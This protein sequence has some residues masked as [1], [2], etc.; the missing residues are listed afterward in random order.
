[1]R[2]L[3]SHG[4]EPLDDV[5]TVGDL[6]KLEEKLDG[7][8]LPPEPVGRPARGP[9]LGACRRD[10]RRIGALDPVDF[11]VFELDSPFDVAPVGGGNP[12]QAMLQTPAVSGGQLWR[13]E[14]LSVLVTFDPA[15]PEDPVYVTV[16]DQLPQVSI[17]PAD[18]S[19]LTPLPPMFSLLDPTQVYD[20]SDNSGPITVLEGNQLTLLFS[21]PN[22][23]QPL[24]ASVA[25]A[26][27]QATIM[28]GTAGQSQPVAGAVPGP[29]I[30]ASL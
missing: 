3:E 8:A 26:R 18:S 22:G 9:E 30:P 6:A 19:V 15:A 2:A 16:F 11:R 17:V 12:Y 23:N 14:R 27:V 20:V 29:S 1:M 4:I 21:C 5:A 7:E 10:G 24:G 13:I 25:A 28:Q